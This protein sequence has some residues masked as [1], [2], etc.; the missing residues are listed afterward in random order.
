VPPPPTETTARIGRLLPTLLVLASA[1]GVWSRWQSLTRHPGQD[2]GINGIIARNYLKYGFPD[3][4]LA[5]IVTPGPVV[6]RGQRLYYVTHPPLA[7]MMDA[8][9]VALLGPSA[10]ALRLPHLLLDVAL[11]VVLARFAAALYGRAAGLWCG[12][13][14]AALPLCGTFSF[15]LAGPVGSP[16][17]LC[18]TLA[19]FW[20]Y[21]YAT[22]GHRRHWWAFVAASTIGFLIDWPAYIPCFVLAGHALLY[23]TKANRR[24][25]VLATAPAFLI[26]MIVMAYALVI[27]VEQHLYGGLYLAFGGWSHAEEV[28]Y[29]AARWVANVGRKYVEQFTPFA[30]LAAAW[31]LARLPRAAGHRD[32]HPDHHLLLQWVWPLPYVVAFHRLFFPHVHYHALFL[33]A[34]VLTLGLLASR[35]YDGARWRGTGRGALAVAAVLLFCVWSRYIVAGCETSILP[36]RG[37]T[38]AWADDLKEHTTPD[39]RSAFARHYAMQM[40]FLA[41]R[42]VDEWVDTAEKL[43]ALRASSVAP[44]TRLFVP[45]GYPFGQ[46]GFGGVLLSRFEAH[47]GNATAFFPLG[48]PRSGSAA[49][50]QRH[51]PADL[52]GGIRVREVAFAAFGSQAGAPLFYFA[53]VADALPSVRADE[54]LDWRLTFR[55]TQG[56]A[57]G[58]RRLPARASA[59]Y[60]VRAPAGWSAAAGHVDVALVRSGTD[61]SRVGVPKRLARIALRI[62]TLGWLGQPEPVAT[63]YLQAGDA[64]IQLR[65]RG[66]A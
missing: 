24:A 63:T 33:P 36:W 21:R 60:F 55:T 10:E 39:E 18:T 9:G 12:I 46:A 5:Q 17:L 15:A 65:T 1:Y 58:T 8:L 57:L 49:P 44:P 26:V 25:M 29:T 48:Q 43:A 64:P 47:V 66:G 51:G 41:D 11:V 53:P 59:S 3:A 34:V 14:G 54:S 23:R 32:N 45:L 27:P 52:E 50:I 28:T 40:R 30:L 35:L 6:P 22:T 62:A 20:Y 19:S 42:H 38:L 7:P 56:E 13:V 2:V 31:F 16:L 61:S 37:R 4:G